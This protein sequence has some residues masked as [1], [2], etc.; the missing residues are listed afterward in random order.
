MPSLCIGASLILVR[1]RRHACCSL[2]L[3]TETCKGAW[4]AT[5]LRLSRAVFAN[6][7]SA[8]VLHHHAKL[9][10]Q[11]S[12]HIG[13]AA[14]SIAANLCAGRKSQQFPTPILCLCRRKELRILYVGKFAFRLKQGNWLLKTGILGVCTFSMTPPRCK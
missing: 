5:P 6:S 3:P 10:G 14:L 12:N 8:I 1:P 9:P 7:A 2:H 13:N 11:L 4:L